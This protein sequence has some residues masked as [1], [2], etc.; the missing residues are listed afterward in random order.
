MI[1]TYGQTP[2]QLFTSPHVQRFTKPSMSP[3][4]EMLPIMGMEP[5][6]LSGSLKD[7]SQEA[8][9]ELQQSKFFSS[10]WWNFNMLHT[11]SV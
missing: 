9:D 7:N 10:E 6:I 8:K 4:A 11:L 1:E 2:C 3:L 5:V